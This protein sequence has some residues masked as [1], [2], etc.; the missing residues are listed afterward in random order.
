LE[1]GESVGA[2]EEDNVT[3]LGFG[4]KLRDV[5]CV[6]RDAFGDIHRVKACSVN[7]SEKGKNCG[8]RERRE[9]ERSREQERERQREAERETE[10]DRQRQTERS[11]ESGQERQTER[12]RESEKAAGQR[13]RP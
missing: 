3:P 8:E 12:D 1:V 13:H 5:D 6:P 9:R 7:G 10:T 11:R 2:L 4:A